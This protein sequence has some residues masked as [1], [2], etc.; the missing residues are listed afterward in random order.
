M[1]IKGVKMKRWDRYAH[2]TVF[3]PV[4][5]LKQIRDIL[6]QQQEVPTE[7]EDLISFRWK[8]HPSVFHHTLRVALLY[9][10]WQT[11]LERMITDSALNPAHFNALH[12]MKRC[13]PDGVFTDIP[14]PIHCRLYRVCPWCRYRKALEI[15]EHLGSKLKRNQPIAIAK[16]LSPL[17]ESHDGVAGYDRV[18]Q[19]TCKE[20]N[21]FLGDYVITL[22]SWLQNRDHIN[23]APGNYLYSGMWET[24]IIAYAKKGSPL[25]LPEEAVTA[26]AREKA[27]MNFHTPGGWVVWESGT[28]EALSEA[29]KYAMAYPLYLLSKQMEAEDINRIL[30]RGNTMRAVGHGTLQMSIA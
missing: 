30:S 25:V 12:E 4:S 8:T 18:I 26:K 27:G 20:R 17:E 21:H 11:V 14:N 10:K 2:E 19:A 24:S 6:D 9:S 1:I 15:L 29:L 5:S 3:G 7:I 16:I 28:K 22:P 23:Q 13:A